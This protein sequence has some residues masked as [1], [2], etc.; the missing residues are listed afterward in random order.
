MQSF[1]EYAKNTFPNAIFKLACVGWACDYDTRQS[2][3]TKT[4]KAYTQC[5]KFGCQYLKNTEY[6]LHD[7]SLFGDD[8][9]HPN[10]EG[11]NVLSYYLT[12]A[13][14]NGGCNVVR[15]LITPIYQKDENIKQL[16]P[17]YILETQINDRID[18]IV[19]LGYFT[20][21]NP[22]DFNNRTALSILK[23]TKNGLILG[24]G[25]TLFRQ[26]QRC[27]CS[28]TENNFHK[29]YGSYSI[30]YSPS[31]NYGILKFI[32]QA[33]NENVNNLNAFNTDTI[34]ISIPAL[35]C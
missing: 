8:N 22:V 9:Y 1:F 12:D 34:H 13:I 21:T 16:N 28:D 2:I 18:F 19:N 30:V 3:G 35:Y 4:L 11:Q 15:S 17:K 7:Y 14:L 26:Y 25:L 20:L 33:E 10:Q 29:I 23:L 31:N 6:I 5:G 24:S 32:A 27:F